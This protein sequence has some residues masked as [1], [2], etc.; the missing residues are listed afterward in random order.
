[1][2]DFRY[3]VEIRV[4]PARIWPVLLDVEHWP[5]WTT[6]VT[7]VQ[8]MDIGPLTLGSR[9]RIWQPR[10]MS[11]VWCV[12]SLDQRSYNFTWATHTCGVKIIGRHQIVPVK[13]HSRVVLTLSYTGLLGALLARIYRDLT[14][15]YLALEGNGLRERCEAPLSHPAPA[16]A[17]RIMT[18]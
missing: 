3:A 4:S 2:F 10:L 8:R 16:K 13:A 18:S 5:E 7:K 6:S 12:T 11:A 17:Q 15:N 14:W 1:M 9:T